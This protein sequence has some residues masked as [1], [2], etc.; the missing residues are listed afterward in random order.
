MDLIQ[1]RTTAGSSKT[2]RRYSEKVEWRLTAVAPGHCSGMFVGDD[3]RIWFFAYASSVDE[4]L[5][6][7][8]FPEAK[9]VCRATLNGFRLV[10]RLYADIEADA[11]STVHGIVYEMTKDDLDSLDGHEGHPLLYAR[12]FQM[13]QLIDDRGIEELRFYPSYVYRMTAAAAEELGNGEIMLLVAEIR[14]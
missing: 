14:A 7:V 6:R 5:M 13:A 2:V 8:R 12:D 4:N 9:T 10:E 3:L 11:G 1:Y